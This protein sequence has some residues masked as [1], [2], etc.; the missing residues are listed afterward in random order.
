VQ[1]TFNTAQ[2]K[3]RLSGVSFKKN[4]DRAL[5][6]IRMMTPPFQDAPFSKSNTV[7]VGGNGMR[8]IQLKRTKITLRSI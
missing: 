7:A 1:K 8:L 6:H 4:K 2:N 5:R 3:M